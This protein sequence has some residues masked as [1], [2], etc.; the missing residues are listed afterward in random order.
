MNTVTLPTGA[1]IDLKKKN[2]IA[3]VFNHL[4]AHYILMDIKVTLKL[5]NRELI[6]KPLTVYNV[7]IM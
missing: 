7:A 5:I 6:T 4:V 2:R 1:W 3:F